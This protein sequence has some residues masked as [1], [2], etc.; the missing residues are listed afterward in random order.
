DWEAF[1]SEVYRSFSEVIFDGLNG[2]C[3]MLRRSTLEKI[4]LLDERVQAADWDLYYTLRKREVELGDVRR[5]K[6][7]GGCYVHHFIRATVKGRREPF[8]CTHP[9]LSIHDKWSREE[10]ERLW[11]KSNYFRP[12]SGR[13]SFRD[14]LR[15]HV[16]K[17]LEK[18]AREWQ[19]AVSWRWLYVQPEK[20]VE[21]HRRQIEVLGTG[22]WQRGESSS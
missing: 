6:I 19:R 17:P 4:G 5:C 20:I 18:L 2:S 8:A 14:L 12:A 10:Q 13:P 9:R 1:C 16:G 15:R 7:F 3:V 11:Y 21:L 22:A